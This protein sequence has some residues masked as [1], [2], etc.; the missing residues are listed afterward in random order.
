MRPES[1]RWIVLAHLIRP[2]GRKGELLAELYTDFPDR[3]AGRDGLHLAR[4]GFDGDT[5][6]ARCIQIISSWLPVGK[7]KGRIV[8]KLDGVDTISDAETL[9]GFDLITADDLRLPLEGESVY[10]SDLIGCTLY[11][12]DI[13]VGTIE[14]IQFPSSLDGVRI[15]DAAALLEIRSEAG[16][17]LIPFV[18]DFLQ[19]MDLPGRRIVM[20][21]PPGLV[22]INRPD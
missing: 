11:D 9:M 15:P 14:D 12:G 8:L 19:T 18:K 13:E 6:Q 1:S 5:E 7:N 20:S 10:I 3:L 17:A 2:Q 21:L 22:A 4:P 16:E